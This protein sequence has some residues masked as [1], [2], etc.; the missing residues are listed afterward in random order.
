MLY[1]KAKLEKNSTGRRAAV[2]G[3]YKQITLTS[4]DIED[5]G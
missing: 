3:I 2:D 4:L 5:C 1:I